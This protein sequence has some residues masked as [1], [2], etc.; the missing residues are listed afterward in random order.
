[1]KP[2]V[3]LLAVVVAIAGMAF[4]HT[5]LGRARTQG[6]INVPPF[7]LNPQW[8]AYNRAGAPSEPSQCFASSQVGGGGGWV[9]LSAI[10]RTT[11]CSSIDFPTGTTT[12]YLAGFMAMGTFNYLYGTL[13]Y[14]AKFGPCQGGICGGMGNW[15]IVWMADVSCQ[16]SDPTGTNGP[17][18]N[19]EIDVSEFLNTFTHV[20]QQIHVNNFTNNDQC[21]T[22]LPDASVNWHVYDLVWSPGQ[23]VW[24]IDGISTCTITQ[25]YVPNA[26]MYVKVTSFVGGVGGGAITSTSFPWLI[27]LDYLT[28]CQGCIGVNP[29]TG[30]TQIFSDQFD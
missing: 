29:P 21:T 27:N 30:G 24:Y 15:P 9:T 20:N 16:A 18:N 22:A 8:L 23:L 10:A 28:I 26:A 4:V 2:T 14:R 6:I 11:T 25:A 13:E 1:M 3:R 17:C 7:A 19:Q 12:S 5:T